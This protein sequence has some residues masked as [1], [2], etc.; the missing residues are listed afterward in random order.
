MTDDGEIDRGGAEVP[1]GDPDRPP[2]STDRPEDLWER[3]RQHPLGETTGEPRPSGETTSTH[4]VIGEADTPAIRQLKTWVARRTRTQVVALVL[5]SLLAFGPLFAV[6]TILRTDQGPVDELI[7][8]DDDDPERTQITATFTSVSTT[9]GEIRTRFTISP[10]RSLVDDGGRLI[11]PLSIVANGT[12]T[13]LRAGEV[14]RPFEVTL[15]M[16]EGSVTRYPFDRYRGQLTLYVTS[17]TDEEEREFVSFVPRVHSVVGD[18][19]VKAQPRT[20]DMVGEQQLTAVDWSAVRPATTT[21]Y[22]IWLMVLMWAL[23]VTGL[24][25]VWSVIM[26]MVELPMWVF[27]YFVGVLFAL[28][29]LRD[30]LPGRPPPGTLFDFLSFYWSVTII[31]VSLILSLSTWL[32]RTRAEQRLRALDSGMHQQID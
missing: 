16:G 8:V 14:V 30:S 25:I 32:T 23:S 12:I 17:T 9:Q 22:A 29:P 26:W 20:P 7:S 27:G 1:A 3:L 2:A 4:I 15:A 19:T 28:P 13:E 10:A 18:F 21:V 6:V 31:G 11:D 5:V 24:L